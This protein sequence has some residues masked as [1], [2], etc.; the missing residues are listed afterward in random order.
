MLLPSKGGVKMEK[1]MYI[2]AALIVVIIVL[3]VVIVCLVR[4]LR[5]IDTI[6]SE[7]NY[8]EFGDIYDD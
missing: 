3:I 8:P 1:Y 2:I 7:L 5:F 4:K 6:I